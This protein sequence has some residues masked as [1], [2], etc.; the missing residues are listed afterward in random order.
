MASQLLTA[1]SESLLGIA[2]T[3]SH[4]FQSGTPHP[5]SQIYWE[6]APTRIH[7]LTVTTSNA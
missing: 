4:L 1:D 5:G 7:R 3:V 2:V 6:S